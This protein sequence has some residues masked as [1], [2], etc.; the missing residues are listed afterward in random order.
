M[1]EIILTS[2]VLI[3]LLALLRRVLRG[4]ISPCVQYALWLLVAAR[5]LI[6]GTLFDSPV[7]VLGAAQRIQASIQTEE[8]LS[9]SP[10]VNE[11]SL[12]ADGPSASFAAQHTDGPSAPFAALPADG[13]AAAFATKP[14]EVRRTEDIPGRVWKAGIWITGGAMAVSNL[15]F[16]LRLRKSR[17]RLE[18][19]A[20][21]WAGDLPLY[22]ADG[23]PSPCL[24]GL[25]QP[26]VYL[27]EAAMEAEHPEHILA[28]EYAHYRHGDHLW[29]ILRC[30]CLAVHWYNPLVWWAAALSRRD[31]ELAC[32]AS[33][34]RR[35]GE[36]ERIDYGQT[37][38]RM[39]SKRNPPSALLHMAT[40]MTAGKRAMTERVAL[41]IRQPR[42]RKLTLA[43]AAALACLLAAC[44]FGG[45]SGGTQ[46]SLPEYPGLHWNDSPAA[47]ME[48]LGIT[49][50]DFLSTMKQDEAG[51]SCRTFAFDL[52]NPAFD[53][54][55]QYAAFHFSQY[56]DTGHGLGLDMVTMSYPDD[57]DD[58]EAFD[59][60][61]E[62][63][64]RQYGRAGEL[65]NSPYTADVIERSLD[66][67][68]SK[69]EIDAIVGR[70]HLS[71]W[72][73]LQNQSG[74]HY[75]FWD[76]GT[77]ALPKDQAEALTELSQGGQHAASGFQFAPEFP[78]MVRV[79]WT[80]RSLEEYTFNQITYDARNYVALLQP[81]TVP[82]TPAPSPLL[83]FPGLHWNDTPEAVMKALGITEEDF[84]ES[85]EDL[86]GLSNSRYFAIGDYLLYGHTAQY[87]IFHFIQ[88]VGTGHNMGL[89]IVQVCYPDDMEDFGAVRSELV[90]QYGPADEASDAVREINS[91]WK[92]LLG[93]RYDRWVELQQQSGTNFLRWTAPMDSQTQEALLAI[94]ENDI[95]QHRIEGG[96]PFASLSWNS[97]SIFTPTFNT[98][99][100]D[101][102]SYVFTLQIYSVTDRERDA[103]RLVHY[104][105]LGEDPGVWLR[106]MS[107]TGWTAIRQAA[108]DEGLDGGD[109]SGFAVQ[110]I[111]A[112]A[113]YV[114]RQGLSLT[115]E[116]CR[117][118]LDASTGL[119]GAV[120]DAYQALVFRLH[121]VTP[122][123]FADVVLHMPE[124]AQRDAILDLFRYGRE[125]GL[126]REETVSALEREWENSLTAAPAEMTLAKAGETFQFL[127]V[128]AYGEYTAVYTSSDPDVV[129]A[130]S[131]GTITARS[132]GEADVTLHFNG[133]QGQR[134]FVCH[135]TC[136]W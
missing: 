91:N 26:A 15:V 61:R 8:T 29:S 41:I 13:P 102:S 56:A 66:D 52:E 86:D 60:L 135:V 16:Y 45:G 116:E 71:Q 115:E 129:W 3:L 97:S 73:A 65:D 83:E 112:A 96:Q 77:D 59:A 62:E 104:V 78:T 19:P 33:A 44:A 123:L 98:V 51:G 118:I 18:A 117:D 54:A 67:Q 11:P 125:S 57:P 27:N 122:G 49:E 126:S 35:L 48:A 107:S 101:G 70:D 30:V 103:G 50:E 131:D 34:L 93:D 39:V 109:G 1:T 100:F 74:P 6:P 10:A 82:D 55:A 121:D 38:L 128:G 79:S 87:V 37:L 63:L 17:K 24:F 133:A 113:Q 7:S 42:T 72:E 20:A 120:A 40:T 22:E 136:Q 68:H 43:L 75:F 94:Q 111:D 47:V 80:D 14:Q 32:D 88:H 85:G 90:R 84:L 53:P 21:P 106:L 4:R 105:Q 69:R 92:N 132:P 9:G 12:P 89:S 81:A 2:S 23:L 110:I 76:A 134:E 114:D 64:A 124:G 99:T 108:V 25:V 46:D 36:G 130:A 58:M 5:L 28:H 119:D 95:L 127:P 31:C